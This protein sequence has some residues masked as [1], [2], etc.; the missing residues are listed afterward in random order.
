[1]K[2]LCCCGVFL[3]IVV[4]VLIAMGF[5]LLMIFAAFVEAFPAALVEALAKRRRSQGYC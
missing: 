5:C 1:M 4:L 3:L 2:V